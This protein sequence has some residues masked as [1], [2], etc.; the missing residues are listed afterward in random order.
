MPSKHR[1]EDDVTLHVLDL[2]DEGLN[3][4]QIGKIVGMSPR[5]VRQRIRNVVEE[6]CAHDPEAISHWKGTPK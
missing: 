3:P 4:E 5:N 2:H 6:D 1:S